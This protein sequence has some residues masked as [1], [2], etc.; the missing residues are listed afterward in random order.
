MNEKYDDCDSFWHR[1]DDNWHVA[2]AVLCS[3]VSQESAQSRQYSG[4]W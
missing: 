1:G 4:S 3:A 2:A